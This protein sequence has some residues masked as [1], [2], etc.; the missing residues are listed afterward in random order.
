MGLLF[1]LLK[2][3]PQQRQGDK[4]VYLV[5]R[6]WYEEMVGNDDRS[7]MEVFIFFLTEQ[8]D[9][10][11]QESFPHKKAVTVHQSYSVK[12]YQYGP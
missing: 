1:N 9:L 7:C 10:V 11:L 8:I 5:A 6:N 2:T 12:I 3:L 4:T